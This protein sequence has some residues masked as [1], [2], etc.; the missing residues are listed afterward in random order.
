MADFLAFF[1]LETVQITVQI[2]FKVASLGFMNQI[3]SIRRESA[4]WR[5]WPSKGYL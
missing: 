4:K 2:M 3:D 5:V 1:Y